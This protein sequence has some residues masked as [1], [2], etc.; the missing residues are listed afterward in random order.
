MSTLHSYINVQALAY[1]LCAVRKIN[2]FHRYQNEIV[3]ADSTI[4]FHLGRLRHDGSLKP[5]CGYVSWEA[6]AGLLFIGCDTIEYPYLCEVKT[7]KNDSIQAE[8]RLPITI[9]SKQTQKLN[10][11]F[12]SSIEE[13]ICPQGHITHT[14]LACDL[15]SMCWHRNGR[16]GSNPQNS[17][18]VCIAPLKPLPPSFNCH[19][20]GQYVPYTLVCDH[21]SDCSDGSDE[22]FCVFHEGEEFI[23][24]GDTSIRCGF[25]QEVS[26]CLR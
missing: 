16:S 20:N 11:S 4:G 15:V 18:N 13:V 10:T 14:F 17:D 12:A 7:Q 26:H 21:R 9:L 19:V 24:L 25:T 3:L 5:F 22:D 6:N 2:T 1:S 23:C 8:R